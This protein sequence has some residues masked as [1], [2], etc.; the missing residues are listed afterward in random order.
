MTHETSGTY[1]HCPP[2]T[3]LLGLWT[4]ETGDVRRAVGPH[5]RRRLTPAMSCPSDL[6]RATCLHTGA[7]LGKC[8]NALGSSEAK[9][10]PRGDGIGWAKRAS[11]AVREV[12]CLG[13]LG[14][15]RRYLTT[16][17]PTLGAL[18]FI[19]SLLL[20]LSSF[21]LPPHLPPRSHP[22]NSSQLPSQPIITLR[23]SVP[24]RLTHFPSV[25]SFTIPQFTIPPPTITIP[26]R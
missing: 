3:G 10:V 22:S 12:T 8:T 26:A 21:F 6:D 1:L 25:L 23:V 4:C 2:F 5:T 15:R 14:T 18:V 7:G 19:P 17:S 20:V 13:A 11:G 24:F 16:S 9:F